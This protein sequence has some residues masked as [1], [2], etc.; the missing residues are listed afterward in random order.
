MLSFGSRIYGFEM[1]FAGV[2]AFFCIAAVAIAAV[3]SYC[4]KDCT[5]GAGLLN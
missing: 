3:N 1:F 2:C 5:E 4:N